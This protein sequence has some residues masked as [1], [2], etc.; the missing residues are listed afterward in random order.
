MTSLPA[1]FA[2]LS[3]ATRFAIVERLMAT[4]ARTAGELADVAPISAPA[5]SRHLRVLREAGVIEQRIEGPKR[6][7]SVRPQAIRAI[8]DWTMDHRT[9]WEGSLDRLA[10][11]LE[12]RELDE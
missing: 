6:I 10:R 2:A 12:N 1:T 7:Y 9:F 4:G 3:D 8:S 5:I 11:A